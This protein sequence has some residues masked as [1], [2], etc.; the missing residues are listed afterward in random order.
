VYGDEVLSTGSFELFK[1][2]L[3]VVVRLWITVRVWMVKVR[4]EYGDGSKLGGCLGA[5]RAEEVEGCLGEGQSVLAPAH[6]IL[7]GWGFAQPLENNTAQNI[8]EE[9]KRLQFHTAPA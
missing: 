2:A 6:P 9:R 8:G 4:K 5:R 7:A 3:I 1:E